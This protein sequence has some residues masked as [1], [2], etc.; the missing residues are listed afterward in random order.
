MYDYNFT[1]TSLCP[2]GIYAVAEP[3]NTG[4]RRIFVL[5]VDVG[6]MF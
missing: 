5:G 4:C 1:L 2:M 6:E 3:L